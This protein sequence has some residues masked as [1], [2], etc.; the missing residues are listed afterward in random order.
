MI[1]IG[2]YNSDYNYNRILNCAEFWG[3]YNI[4]L[5]SHLFCIYIY[6]TPIR[7]LIRSVTYMHGAERK[8][9]S[10]RVALNCVSSFLLRSKST[11]LSN[12]LFII[13]SWNRHSAEFRA[14]NT[15]LDLLISVQSERFEYF[16]IITIVK[17]VR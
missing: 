2:H 5:W 16:N 8:V 13:P 10:T 12:I 14:L 11:F 17:V 9:R 1:I 3:K 4:K 15:G 6:K 7:L